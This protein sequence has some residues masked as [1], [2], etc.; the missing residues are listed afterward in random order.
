MYCFFLICIKFRILFNIMYIFIFCLPCCPN[1]PH[2]FAVFFK[3]ILYMFFCCLYVFLL[4]LRCPYFF[5]FSAPFTFFV[6]FASV[7]LFQFVR[8]M[9]I[10]YICLACIDLRHVPSNTLQ[11]MIRKNTQN[12]TN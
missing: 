5:K 6:H 9:I 8:E 2:S 12:N 7:L 1:F 4:L 3:N 10:F 11:I